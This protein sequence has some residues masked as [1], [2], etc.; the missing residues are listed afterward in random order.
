MGRRKS[1]ADFQ[2]FQETGTGFVL[3]LQLLAVQELR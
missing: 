2:Q 1:G 3:I